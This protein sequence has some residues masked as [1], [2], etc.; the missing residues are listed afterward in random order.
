MSTQEVTASEI[1]PKHVLEGLLFA[2]ATPMS[3]NALKTRMPDEAD[4]PALIEE[5][6]AEYANRAVEIVERA[7]A[8]AFRTR[9]ELA[10]Y[11]TLEKEETR[12]L[13]RAALE[14]MAVIAYHQPVTRT[15]IESI[16]GVMTHKGT[17]DILMEM[18]WIKPGKRRE[19]PG[20]PLT[21]LTTP[22]FLDHFGLETLNELP[23]LEDLKAAGLLDARP[24]ID[25]LPDPDLFDGIE[26]EEASDND[27]EDDEDDEIDDDTYDS[28]VSLDD[29][30]DESDDE[31][32]DEDSEDETAEDDDEDY[33]DDDSDDEEEDED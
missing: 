26:A 11:L 27:S 1:D 23:G 13:S 16:R 32:S 9:T 33:D 12:K 5:L 7:G 18:G 17:L 8:Y 29:A 31:E 25:T 2:S 3:V 15:E 24:A 19:I 14:T 21:W 6:R 20:R 10:P 30:D 28:R 22:A 4:I